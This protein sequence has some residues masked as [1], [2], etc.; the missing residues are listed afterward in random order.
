MYVLP[1]IVLSPESNFERYK[2]LKDHQIGFLM[3]WIPFVF[4]TLKAP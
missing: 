2:D 4:K 1:F 3:E